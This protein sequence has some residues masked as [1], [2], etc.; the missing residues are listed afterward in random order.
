MDQAVTTNET[1]AIGPEEFYVES[2]QTDQLDLA[3]L[4]V[5]KL[6][7][8]ITKDQTAKVEGQRAKYTY[9]FT[10]IGNVIEAIEQVFAE[11]GVIIR[12]PLGQMRIGMNGPELPILTKLKHAAS[13]QFCHSITPVPV[14]KNPGS[15]DYGSAITYGR[16]YTLLSLLGMAP[17]EKDD[18]GAGAQRNKNGGGSNV[19]SMLN[20]KFS[21]LARKAAEHKLDANVMVQE[22][23][24]GRFNGLLDLQKANEGQDAALKADARRCLQA[25]VQTIQAMDQS[26]GVPT[27]AVETTPQA[28]AQP[29][30][31]AAASNDAAPVER[32]RGA[33]T[34]A[35][36]EEQA[37]IDG[38]VAKIEALPPKWRDALYEKLEKETGK[39]LV[40]FHDV[41]MLQVAIVK[42]QN[43]LKEQKAAS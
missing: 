37:M 24:G 9:D 27:A 29:V 32:K 26:K 6:G 17:T 31:V 38:T 2:A 16:R 5:K 1:T 42:C 18:D 39:G 43:R 34:G 14:T 41:P 10:S 20:P 4:E 12:Q 36:A 3:I 35:S 33:G 19:T 15:Q 40:E 28:P 7:I 13:G 30:E 21:S 8:R 25:I 11:H 23:S 22:T